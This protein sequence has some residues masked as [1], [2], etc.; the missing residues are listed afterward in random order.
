MRIEAGEDKVRHNGARGALNSSGLGKKGQDTREIGN[1]R[2]SNG[3]RREV[4]GKGAGSGS[5]NV[6]RYGQSYG[7]LNRTQIGSGRSSGSL[8]LGSIQNMT[9]GIGTRGSG[10]PMRMRQ[11]AG[12]SG[13]RSKQAIEVITV[14]DSEDEEELD[15]LEARLMRM[16][17]RRNGRRYVDINKRSQH[18][19]R[20]KYNAL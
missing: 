18:E 1:V 12:V 10:G 9:Q 16:V 14:T 20:G 15:E 2:C 11:S 5:L 17:A 8:G 19:T 3:T 13:T 4:K 7:R 6:T